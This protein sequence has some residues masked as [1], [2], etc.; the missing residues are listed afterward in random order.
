MKNK[1]LHGAG[2]FE[3]RLDELQPGETEIYDF[4]NIV[5]NGSKGGL[6]KY[7]PFDSAQV[8]NLSTERLGITTN[9]QF[10]DIVVP[11]AVETYENQGVVRMSITN[12]GSTAI[13]S[14]DIVLTV[15]KSPYDADD[16]ARDSR[17]RGQVS[18]I[19]EKFTGVQL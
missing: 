13:A 1:Q 11:N 8:T 15:E 10:N 3:Y 5:H 4:R 14:G 16:R 19:V 9:E 18:R 7:L 6:K 12:E 17:Q 2:P